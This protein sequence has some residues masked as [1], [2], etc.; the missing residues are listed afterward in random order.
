VIDGV[1]EAGEVPRPRL[2]SRS[3][4]ERGVASAGGAR[5]A[6]RCSRSAVGGRLSAVGCRRSAVG[7][8]QSAVCGLRSAVGCR[9]SAVGGQLSAFGFRLS[10]RRLGQM[11]ATNC[12]SASRSLAGIAS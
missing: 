10:V 5:L 1:G 2:N 12:T 11:E 9:R 6:E 3:A 4:A 8:R 7:V